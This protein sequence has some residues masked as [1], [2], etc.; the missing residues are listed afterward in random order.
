MKVV[1]EIGPLTGRTRYLS[2]WRGKLILQVEY[3]Y[4]YYSGGRDSIKLVKKKSLVFI[5]ETLP[6][7]T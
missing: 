6:L 2:N 1:R 4:A 3:E 5:G 7:K